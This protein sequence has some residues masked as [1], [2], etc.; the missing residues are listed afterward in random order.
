MWT[1][2]VLKARGKVAFKS[3]YWKSVLV[4]LIA[5]LLTTGATSSQ[6]R[7]GIESI[8]DG[9]ITFNAGDTQSIVSL[10]LFTTTFVLVLIIAIAIDIFLVKPLQV[11]CNN[12]FILN[13]RD[14]TTNIDALERGFTCN[15]KNVVKV[16]FMTNL[17]I[18][19]WSL[20]FI[21][22]GIYKSYQYRLV[23]YLIAE[24][25]DMEYKDAMLLSKRLMDGNKMAAFWLDLSFIGW[26]MLGALTFGIL[27]VLYVNPYVE[28]T[29]CE[30]YIAL[31]HPAEGSNLDNGPIDAQTVE[32]TV[33]E[34]DK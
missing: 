28:A 23:P 4:A 17:V 27:T 3:N 1:R 16:Q 6:G 25:P 22:P 10:G 11:G 14:R 32:Y 9:S 29:N 2:S 12:F 8:R 34:N 26:A 7:S 19:L 15:Y 5:S 21:I 31:A 13:R 20:L 18:A 24:D 30:L 33:E